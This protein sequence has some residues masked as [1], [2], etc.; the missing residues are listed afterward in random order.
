MLHCSTDVVFLSIVSLE[1]VEQFLT[2]EKFNDIITSCHKE[3]DFKPL[4]RLLGDV[5]TKSSSLNISFPPRGNMEESVDFDSAR[6]MFEILFSLQNS[7]I[8][9]TLIN[10]LGTLSTGIEVELKSKSYAIDSTN[11]FKQFLIIFENPYL[12]QPE[13]LENALPCFCKAMSLLPLNIQVRLVH[14]WS[15]HSRYSVKKKVEILQQLITLRVIA[16]PSAN[17]NSMTV[18]EDPVIAHATKCL[19]LFYYASHLGGKF[20][21]LNSTDEPMD[22]EDSDEDDA[23]VKRLE[24]DVLDCRK[25]LLPS[26]E[27]INEPLNE[28][29]AVDRDFTLYKTK[30]GFS[31]MECNF[32]LTTHIKSVWMFYDNRVHMLQERRLTHIYSLLQGRQ[33]TPYLKLTVHRENLI[34]DALINVSYCL[35]FIFCNLLTKKCGYVIADLY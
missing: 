16:G 24:L 9:N 35:F 12:N 2:E 1:Q 19:K 7:A 18:N 21:H 15:K 5:F 13:Y 33:P 3:N 11:Y 31:F 6:T 25:P 10:S 4:V 22:T 30:E 14:A 34:Q 26:D 27:F 29:I 17:S 23:L 20:D 8:E 32:I 28:A